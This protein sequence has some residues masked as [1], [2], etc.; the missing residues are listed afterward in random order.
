[1]NLKG[2]ILWFDNYKGVAF[3]KCKNNIIYSIG[4]SS[5]LRT[6]PEDIQADKEVE[7]GDP[8]KYAQSNR[9]IN[10]HESKIKQP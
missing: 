1:M 10:S 7:F 5:I 3:I 8:S 9:K 4:Y 2:N 6:K